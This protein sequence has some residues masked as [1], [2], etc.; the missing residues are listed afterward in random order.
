MRIPMIL[1][2]AAALALSACDTPRLLSINP[3]VT[4]SETVFDQTL[5]GTWGTK[6]GAEFCSLRPNADTNTYTVTYVSDGDSRKF[7]GR[8]FQAG[9]ARVMDLAPQDQDDFQI[10]GHALIRILSSGDTLRWTYLDSDWL[11]QRGAAELPNHPRGGGKLLLSAPSDRLAAFLATYAAD[12]RAHGDI[13]EW[14]RL[15]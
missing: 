11:R 5:V 7:E 1:A 13:Q 12:E 4:E 9:Q 3:A 15:Q 14:Q 2:A 10:P 8:L 6:D